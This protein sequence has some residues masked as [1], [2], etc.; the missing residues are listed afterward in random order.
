MENNRRADGDGPLIASWAELF[1]DGLGPPTI[2]LNLGISLFAVYTFVIA[3]IMPTVVA[4]IGGLAYY[5]WAAM[6]YLTGSIVG[7]ASAG[8]VTAMMGSRKGDVSAGGLFVI[9][10]AGCGSSPNMAALLIAITVLGV[11]G[12]LIIALSYG[13]VRELFA[14]RLR[15]RTLSTIT[16]TWAAAGII[17]PLFGGIAIETGWWRGAFWAMVPIALLFMA[18]AW[19]VFP[20]WAGARTSADF[21]FLRLALLGTAILC[22]GFSGNVEAMAGRLGLIAAAVALV[23]LT[24]RYDKDAP[25]RLFPSRPLSL[26]ST[27]GTGHWIIVLISFVHSAIAVHLTLMLQVMHGATPLIAGYFLG[28]LSVAWTVGAAGTAG[29]RGRWE[30]MSLTGG[31]ILIVAGSSVLAITFEDVSRAVIIVCLI[32]IGLGIGMCILHMTARILLAAP[33]GEEGIT[34]TSQASVRTLGA[35]F[36]A[37]GAGV[38]ANAAGLASGPSPETVTTAVSWV[39]VFTIVAALATLALVTNELRLARRPA[40]ATAA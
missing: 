30:R 17:G 11:G 28:V 3:T 29:W 16:V 2:V 19:R 37:A 7:S 12:G 39:Y 26:S 9:G 6:L 35:A 10:L 18:L 25:N 8:P 32:A 4:E 21:P 38:I 1:R 14:P 24:L 34:A 15:T 27:V 5:A 20:R 40:Q 31:P 13:F 22:V 33:S 36:G 23:V